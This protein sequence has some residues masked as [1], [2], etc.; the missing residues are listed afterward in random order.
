[1]IEGSLENFR[2]YG[3]MEKQKQEVSEKRK[4]QSEKRKSQKKEDA[5]AQEGEKSRNTVFS[6]VL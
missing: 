6:T 1:M 5:G 3:Q 4:S 2:Q